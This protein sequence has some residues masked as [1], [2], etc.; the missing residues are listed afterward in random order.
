MANSVSY[1][2]FKTS[3]NAYEKVYPEKNKNACQN[4]VAKI[5]KNMKKIIHHLMNC[6]KK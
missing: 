4:A 3:S 2:H 6:Q 1:Q 5:W